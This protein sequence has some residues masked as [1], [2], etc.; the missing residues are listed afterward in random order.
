V[1]RLSVHLGVQRSIDGDG[2]VGGRCVWADGRVNTAVTSDEK[3]KGWRRGRGSRIR[4]MVLDCKHTYT[5]Q[6]RRFAPAPALRHCSQRGQSGHRPSTWL[7]P[8]LVVGW[9]CPFHAKPSYLSQG[10]LSF[11]CFE[12]LTLQRTS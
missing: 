12:T 4:G 11:T 8:K 9:L 5:Q 3:R 6:R 1:A 2:S 7:Y 10:S